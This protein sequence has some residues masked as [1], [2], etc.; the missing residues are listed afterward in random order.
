[1]FGSRTNSQQKYERIAKKTYR[2]KSSKEAFIAWDSDTKEEIELPKDAMLIPLTA[3][4]AITGSRQRGKGASTHYTNVYSN[5]FTNFDSDV[6]NVVEDDR[7]DG[8]K[9]TIVK[10]VYTPTVKEAI[11]DLP[12]ANFTKV[13]Y[14]L[15]DGEVVKMA[16]RSSSLRPWIEFENKLKERHIN[17]Y[18]GYGI[19]LGGVEEGSFGAVKFK[20]PKFAAVEISK[21]ENTKAT[22]LA[23]EVENAILR[24]LQASGAA[25]TPTEVKTTADDIAEGSEEVSLSEIPF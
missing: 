5:E 20:T 1:M 21:E 10:G 13:L 16:L 18:N 14:C 3:T 11:A 22:A 19:K 15:Y 12:Y 24:N 2:W 6:I 25:E 17:L 9:T 4:M 7:F 8:T 23:I